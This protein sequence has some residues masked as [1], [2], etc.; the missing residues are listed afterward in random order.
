MR[1]G[2]RQGRRG[3][4]P[5]PAPT[6]GLSRAGEVGGGGTPSTR[7]VTGRHSRRE[8]SPHTHHSAAVMAR[9][10]GTRGPHSRL[11]PLRVLLWARLGHTP[12]PTATI[13]S[14]HKCAS[15]PPPDP[16]EDG[17]GSCRWGS[18][19]TPGPVQLD[20][21]ERGSLTCKK[22]SQSLNSPGPGPEASESEGARP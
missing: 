18:A 2:P 6:A 15:P 1:P 19:D 10:V 4:G 9:S 12:T 3:R 14:T 17:H 16:H 7:F 21:L 8:R 22:T 20:W 5:Q 11:P 13:C